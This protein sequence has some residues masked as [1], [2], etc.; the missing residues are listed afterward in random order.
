M[1]GTDLEEEP[2][3]IEEFLGKGSACT[4]CGQTGHSPKGCR[5]AILKEH[6]GKRCEHCADMPFRRDKPNCL[7]CGRP[8]EPESVEHPIPTPGSGCHG[9]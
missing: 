4:R 3:S 6:C 2:E 7:G 9:F 1:G 5:R 8:W